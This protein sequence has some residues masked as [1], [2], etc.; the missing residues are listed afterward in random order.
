MNTTKQTRMYLGLLWFAGALLYAAYAAYTY[1]GLF[2]LAC[3]WQ[4][5]VF[6]AHD[7]SVAFMGVLI[8]CSLP[9]FALSPEL[10]KSGKRT[11]TG[12]A[13]PAPVDPVKQAR[14]LALLGGAS[15]LVG[16]GAGLL[17]FAAG[18]RTPVVLNIDLLQ[19]E[20]TRDVSHANQLI[21][22]GMQ[23]MDIAAILTTTTNGSASGEMFIPFTARDWDEHQP[24]RYVLR[25]GVQPHTLQERDTDRPLSFGPAAL[26]RHALPGEV[27]RDWQKRG[28][29]LS[30]SLIVLDRNLSRGNEVPWIVCLF[31]F[32]FGAVFLGM[33]VYLPRRIAAAQQRSARSL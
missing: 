1:T 27:R 12:M 30:P 22:N 2:A 32:L 9:A 19:G 14:M 6:G 13:A 3:D 23:Q 31:G 4:D 21:V 11:G 10:R 24:I 8:L 20:E 28:L 5:H 25:E 16:I 7:T 17:A 29:T 33:G 26:F 15:L 18:H